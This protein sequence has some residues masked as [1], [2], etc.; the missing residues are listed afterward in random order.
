MAARCD[1]GDERSTAVQVAVWRRKSGV[2]GEGESDIERERER[3][4]F[5]SLTVVA[6]T[7]GD[8]NV[9]RLCTAAGVEDEE[10]DREGRTSER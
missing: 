2:K 6:M 3:E 4:N 1:D 8:W 7:I 5:T 10:D 9:R